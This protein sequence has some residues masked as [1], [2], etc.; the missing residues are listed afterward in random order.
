M[1]LSLTWQGTSKGQAPTGGQN[2]MHLIRHVFERVL[3]EFQGCLTARF[4][5]G[6]SLRKCACALNADERA[7]LAL[8]CVV[9]GDVDLEDADEAM[10]ELLALRLVA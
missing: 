6:L 9:L 1:P 7:K 2:G 5:D 3:Q 8:S 4:L 10:L